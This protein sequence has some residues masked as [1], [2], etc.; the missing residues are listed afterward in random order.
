MP[1]TAFVGVAGAGKTTTLIGE[2]QAARDG[3]SDVWLVLCSDSPDLRARPHVKTGG[4]MGSRSPGVKFPISHFVSRVEAAELLDEAAPGQVVA[5]DEASWFGTSLVNHWIDASDRGVVV[6]VSSM[7]EDQIELLTNAGH[8]MTRITL[9]CAL[10]TVGEG[11]N[12]LDAAV[13]ESTVSLTVCDACLRAVERNRQ[14]GAGVESVLEDLAAINPFPGEHRSY[15]PLYGVES[16]GWDFVRMDSALRAE[17][18]M[19]AFS[20]FYGS[21]SAGKSYLDLGCATGFF[22][23]FMADQGFASTGVDIDD[24]FIRVASSVSAMRYSD[25]TYIKSDALSY[26]RENPSEQFDVVSTF[27]TVQWVMAQSGLEAGLEC[28]DWIFR[29]AREMCVVEIGYS[30]EDIYSDKLPV[31]IDRVWMQETMKQRGNF[32]EVLF[33]EAGQHNTWRD[34]FIGLRAPQPAGADQRF[35]GSLARRVG[36]VSGMWDDGWAGAR[37]SFVAA[38]ATG[39]DLVRVTGMVPDWM[40]EPNRVTLRTATQQ[41]EVVV[42][43]GEAF[44]VSCAV[45]ATAGDVVRVTVESH[46]AQQPPN[47]DM[48]YLGFHVRTISFDAQP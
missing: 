3:G 40:D 2:L 41:S 14:G 31:R 12:S 32:D 20:E 21:S 38:V 6:Y 36:E 48:R 13:H 18:M 17:I 16:D 7:S 10:C 24:D 27:A 45:E 33:Y 42:Q 22:C 11:I 4:L 37:L 19:A 9:P 30:K 47:D 8:R 1:L 43:P 35:V 29:A 28:F 5:F 15:Q 26:I 39:A 44:E 46:R 23:E 25:V 34:Q